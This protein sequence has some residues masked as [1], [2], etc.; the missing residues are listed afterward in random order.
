VALV[1]TQRKSKVGE[2]PI[3]FMCKTLHDYELR[4]LELEKQSLSLVKPVADFQTYILNSH[5]IAY[6]P[7]SLV[8]MLL[9]QQF[10][11]GKW[12]NWMEEIQEYDI[13]IKSM[14]A[15]KIIRVVYYWPSVFKDSYAMVR[16][17][18]P[19]QQFLGKMKR[20]VMP[21]QPISVEQLFT[22]WGLDFIG[23]IN[24]KS[25][26]GHMNILTATNYFTK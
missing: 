16:Q 20:P 17:C 24:T 25:I 6:V 8:K 21:L 2:L 22:Q 9:N 11:E 12:A 14:K 26:R 19:Y 1:L 5:A 7:S 3:K 13:E 23:P 15:V 4:Y 18:I 10:K